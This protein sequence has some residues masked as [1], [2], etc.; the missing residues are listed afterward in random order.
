MARWPSPEAEASY[1]LAYNVTPCTL[2]PAA[3]V[4]YE[5]LKAEREAEGA[6]PSPEGQR[7]AR[8]R[9]PSRTP[10]E[11]RARILQM[12]KTINPKY[13]RPFE[14]DRLSVAS[15]MG[16]NWEEYGQVILQMAILDTLLS[17]EELLRREHGGKEGAR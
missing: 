4:A 15:I 1:A 3:Q 14:Q 6:A 8:D 16:G 5:R 9:H 7:P 2:S 10:P 13:A 11:I 12:F 17:I